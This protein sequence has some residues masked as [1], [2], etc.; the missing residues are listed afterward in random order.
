MKQ[1]FRRCYK[2]GAIALALIAL[3]ATTRTGAIAQAVK[4]A[5]V[6]DADNPALAPYRQFFQYN[7][8]ALQ[9]DSLVTTVPAGKRLVIEYVS[10]RS[11]ADGGD[12]LT[13]AELRNG[14]YEDN[15]AIYFEIHP[16]HTGWQTPFEPNYSEQ[17]GSQM[18]KAYF[19]PGT[20]VW[21]RTQHSTNNSR[22]INLTVNGYF[23]A[24]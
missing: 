2:T 16:P 22:W 20:E 13:S 6:R 24:P 3:L 21:L 12:Q 10:Y 5:L 1:I 17:D 15:G 7:W 4:A 9:G 8:T 14:Y 19:E 23:V 11:G 18:V